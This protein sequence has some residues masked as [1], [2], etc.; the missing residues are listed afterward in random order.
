MKKIFFGCIATLLLLSACNLAVVNRATIDA[1]LPH[2]YGPAGLTGEWTSGYSSF[3]EVVEAYD[4]RY[5]ENTR[6]SGKYF[7]IT[8]NGETSELYII[9]KNQRS[10]TATKATG[11]IR[12]DNGSSD[13]SGSFTFLALSARYKSW[14]AENFDREGTESDL[15][16]LT[17]K[18]YYK[19][20]GSWLIIEPGGEPN[21]YSSGF[22]KIN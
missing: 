16:N 9:Q 11:T 22:R 6:R 12:F 19:M 3:S 1:T 10:S 2:T 7:R 8:K 17:R 20:E 15:K 4:G 13:E 18:Y 21:E 14:G 5:P